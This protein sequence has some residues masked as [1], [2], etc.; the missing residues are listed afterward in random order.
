MCAY[1]QNLAFVNTVRMSHSDSPCYNLRQNYCPVI[2]HEWEF[3]VK[4]KATK[5]KLAPL[6]ALG[7]K[8]SLKHE[9]KAFRQQP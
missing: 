4:W 2:L 9:A 5:V 6:E 3:S 8:P 7:I 1:I